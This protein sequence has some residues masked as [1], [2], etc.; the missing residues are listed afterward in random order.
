MTSRQVNKEICFTCF[1]VYEQRLSRKANILVN[2][3]TIQQVENLLN[4]NNKKTM[5][6]SRRQQA[7][8]DLGMNFERE[9]LKRNAALAK[10]QERVAKNRQNANR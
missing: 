2:S 3:S 8:N 10:E 6:S 7:Q 1:M 4:V 5:E 9:D